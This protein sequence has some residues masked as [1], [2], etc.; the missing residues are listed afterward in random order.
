MGRVL[1]RHGVHSFCQ[2]VVLQIQVVNFSL[3]RVDAKRL[4]PAIAKAPGVSAS[5]GIAG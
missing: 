3:D 4:L 2:V 5:H 1:N